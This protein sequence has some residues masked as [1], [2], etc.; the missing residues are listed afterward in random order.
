M[1]SPGNAEELAVA[2]MKLLSLSEEDKKQASK[3]NRELVEPKFSTTAWV[4]RVVKVYEK[5]LKNR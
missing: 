5:A 4:D 2:V 1:V 3:R